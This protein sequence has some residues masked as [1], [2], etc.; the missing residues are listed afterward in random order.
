MTVHGPNRTG[1]VYGISRFCSDRTIN[2]LDLA[3]TLTDDRFS[4]VLQLD[5]QK[6]PSPIETVQ[7]ELEEYSKQ[8]GQTITM[9]HNDIF[10]VTNE[11]ALH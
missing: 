4:M 2:I 6:C 8:S 1:L 11:V 10:Q 3:T 9:Q 5:L 7:F